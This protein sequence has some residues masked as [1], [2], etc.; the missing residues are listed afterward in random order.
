MRDREKQI[1]SNHFHALYPHEPYMYLKAKEQAVI[2]YNNM[3]YIK[4]EVPLY[5]HDVLIQTRGRDKVF[6]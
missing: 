6:N 5:L 4:G 1:A 2:V 3:D